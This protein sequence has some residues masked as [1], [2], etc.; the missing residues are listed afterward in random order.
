MIAVVVVII[1]LHV[2]WVFFYRRENAETA[3]CRKVLQKIFNANNGVMWENKYRSNWQSA[4]PISQWA[5]IEVQDFGKGDVV[6]D[7]QMREN[8]NFIGN[9]II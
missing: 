3:K 6:T 4:A 9:F 7:I 1:S 2:F 5:G 8:K